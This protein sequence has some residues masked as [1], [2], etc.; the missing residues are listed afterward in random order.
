MSK[1]KKK[2]G[3]D[4]HGGGG[5]HSAPIWII[6]FADL[7]VLLMSFFVIIAVGNPKNA[8]YDPDFAEI[9]AAI[10]KAFKYVPPVDSK[11]P[12]D[13]ILLKKQL[14]NLKAH[15]GDS[16][17]S[18]DR[19]EAFNRIEGMSGQ[20]D[21]VTT[22][23]T[24]TQTTIGGV[25]PFALN[26]SEI[27]EKSSAILKRIADQIRGHTNVFLAKGHTSRDE[28]YSIRN[29]EKDLSYQRARAAIK[30][31]VEFGVARE[32]LRIEACRDFEPVKKHA[33]SE[34]NRAN[35]RRVEI[36]ATEALVSEYK[37]EKK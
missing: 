8:A 19:G 9:V 36:I 3:G 7:V 6:S 17:K 2:K 28:E 35:N 29:T 16:G 21:M 31:L 12:V 26:S 15:K 32:S 4:D 30:K 34:V 33:Y 5:G 1:K 20:N 25:I 13:L 18:S 10:K 11:D 24:G 27:T 37:G 14:K 22:V 23:R